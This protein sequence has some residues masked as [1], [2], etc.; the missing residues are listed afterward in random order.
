MGSV[1]SVISDKI[2][3]EEVP[4]GGTVTIFD[5][6]F[7]TNGDLL[8]WYY[9]P[10]VTGSPAMPGYSLN[11]SRGQLI[12]QVGAVY[13]NAMKDL[14]IPTDV[15][16]TVSFD[17]VLNSGAEV[18]VGGPGISASFYSTS[19]SYSLTGVPGPEK[20]G[21]FTVLGHTIII[22]NVKV[23]Y[24][25]PSTT[26]FLADIRQSTE[27]TIQAFTYTT[28]DMPNI[29]PKPAYSGLKIYPLLFYLVLL[30]LQIKEVNKSQNII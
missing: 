3:P 9:D 17:L 22:D 27:Y 18:M 21:F 1:L 12:L 26:A 11:A 6:P 8:G 2:V 19:G 29:A 14:D 28:R 30:Q 4:G 7:T 20:F 13:E 10:S 16:F 23:T 25:S 24:V 15:N 5:D